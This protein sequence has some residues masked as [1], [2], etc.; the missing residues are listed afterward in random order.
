MKTLVAGSDGMVGSAVTHHHLTVRKVLLVCG[1]LSSLLYV[2]INILGALQW[3]G[4]SLISQTIS[5]LSAIDAPSRPL[6]ASL[7]LA[8]DALLVS[9]GLGVWK[10]AGRKRALR[11]VAV[12]L[13]IHG[14]FNLVMGPFASMHQREV[15][16]AGEATLSDTLH[17]I[18]GGVCPL[19]FLLA[20]GFGTVAFGK[21]FRL[22][23][24]ATILALLV[25][26]VLTGIDAP[27]IAANLPTPWVGVWE[28]IVV[29]AFML[30]V[31]V[32]AV[33][34]LRDQPD[35]LRLED[36]ERRSN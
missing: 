6:V 34:L 24:L 5:E 15:L 12:V 10:S 32:L 13:I 3:E 9:F 8:Y 1:I 23:S 35:R 2:A 14:V 30:W 20:A 27:R 16:A 7:T 21:R 4:Y 28:R 18:L 19:S 17:I 29:F 25:F 31:A 33:A 26:G 36:R 22:Y 11:V